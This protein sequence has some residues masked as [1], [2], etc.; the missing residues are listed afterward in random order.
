MI[1]NGFLRHLGGFEF[2]VGVVA[3]VESIDNGSRIAG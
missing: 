3:A 1:C 2:P